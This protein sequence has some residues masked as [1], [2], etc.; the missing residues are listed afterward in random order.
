MLR[1][2]GSQLLNVSSE[3]RLQTTQSQQLVP[4]SNQPAQQILANIDHVDLGA[5]DT[6]G[7]GQQS[8]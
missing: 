4:G 2:R 5:A 6:I 3:C 1:A 8:I 7:H